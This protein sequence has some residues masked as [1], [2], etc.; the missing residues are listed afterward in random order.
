M[1][2]EALPQGK[3]AKFGPKVAK[4][5]QPNLVINK[6]FPYCSGFEIMKGLWMVDEACHHERAGEAIGEGLP[7]LSVKVSRLNIS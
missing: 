7:S 5:R 3:Q 1:F 6:S 4:I 2:W